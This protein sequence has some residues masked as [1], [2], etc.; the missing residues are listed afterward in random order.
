M[1]VKVEGNPGQDNTYSETH[2]AGLQNYAPNAQ[3]VNN[4]NYG[5]G[6]TRSS[7]MSTYFQQLHHEI[8]DKTKRKI[9]DDLL[10]Y[11]TKLD[12]TKGMEEKLKDGGFRDAFIR[13][14]LRKKQQYAKKAMQFDCYPSAQEIN[15]LIFADIINAFTV[16]IEPMIHREE[17]I[18]DVMKQIHE[19]VVSP[20]MAKIN[21]NGA[22]DQ[23]LHYT[24]DHIYGMIYYLTGMCHL[25]WKD[26]DNL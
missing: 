25:N 17:P 12:G 2:L 22:E 8:E 3:T 5:D 23:D 13:E 4:Y 7:R 14:A 10:Y 6:V 21:E 15:L 19:K 9:I 11:T 26:Y 24:A 18:E 1:E 16:Y 20:I